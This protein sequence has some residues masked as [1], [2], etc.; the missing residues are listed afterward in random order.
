M[1]TDCQPPHN[2]VHFTLEQTIT[3]SVVSVCVFPILILALRAISFSSKLP[4]PFKT[5]CLCLLVMDC[6]LSIGTSIEPWLMYFTYYDHAFGDLGILLVNTV[7]AL[8]TLDRTS[9]MK[10]PLKYITCSSNIKFTVCI[11]AS[12]L[13]LETTVYA[14]VCLLPC[15]S[16]VQV[17]NCL[18]YHTNYILVLELTLCTMATTCFVLVVLEM[19]KNKRKHTRRITRMGLPL[20]YANNAT[21]AHVSAILFGI[22][23]T[24]LFSTLFS[25]LSVH[26]CHLNNSTFLAW[27]SILSRIVLF[28]VHGSMFN[29]WFDEGRLHI[30]TLLSPLGTSIRSRADDMRIQVY[31]IV[32]A[33]AFDDGSRHFQDGQRRS[34]VSTLNSRQGTKFSIVTTGGG[35]GFVRRSPLSDQFNDI[36]HVTEATTVV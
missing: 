35:R 14:L 1:N 36:G 28:I 29:I 13:V 12:L 24:M 34:R 26:R 25:I 4:S 16:L 2:A 30:L 18:S 33:Q 31:N 17:P 32:I 15:S 22:F 8:M 9:A 19:M 27:C 10:F 7:T 11:T 21:A 5:L 3:L 6:V 23:P 20:T